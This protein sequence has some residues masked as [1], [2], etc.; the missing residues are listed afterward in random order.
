LCQQ[1]AGARIAYCEMLG[2]DDVRL[3][4]LGDPERNKHTRRVG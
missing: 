2:N 1:A 3:E 4:P